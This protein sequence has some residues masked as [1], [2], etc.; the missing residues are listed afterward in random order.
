M[1]S[2]GHVDVAGSQK[3]KRLTKNGTYGIAHGVTKKKI[4]APFKQ[5]HQNH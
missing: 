3:V 2:P 1:G 4:K 5:W